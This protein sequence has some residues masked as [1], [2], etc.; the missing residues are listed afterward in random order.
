[1]S[2]EYEIEGIHQI[3]FTNKEFFQVQVSKIKNNKHW[4]VMH[5]IPI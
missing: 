2:N 3:S 4:N 1:M 5:H